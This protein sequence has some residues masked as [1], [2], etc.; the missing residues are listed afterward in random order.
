MVC[1]HCL[2]THTSIEVG[3]S[4]FFRL[5]VDKAAEVLDQWWHR[6]GC[7]ADIYVKYSPTDIRVKAMQTAHGA[8]AARDLRGL[9]IYPLENILKD[10]ANGA[11]SHSRF[12]ALILA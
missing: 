2:L 9:T 12:R 4:V 10:T 8:R 3:D 6:L 11:S 1:P 7:D 5:S